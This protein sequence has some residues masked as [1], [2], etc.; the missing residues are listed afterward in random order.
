MRKINQVAGE[1]ASSHIRGTL[2]RGDCRQRGQ[3]SLTL[4]AE[5]ILLLNSPQALL[6]AR[7]EPRYRSICDVTLGIIFF[8]TP[9]RGSKKAVYGKVLANIAQ[10]VA[11]HPSSGLLKAL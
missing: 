6:Q 10:T 1:R 7:L 8:G 2:P 11:R 4:A 5:E 3:R 9:H